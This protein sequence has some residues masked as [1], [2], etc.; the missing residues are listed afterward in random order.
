MIARIAWGTAL[1]LFSS[2]LPGQASIIPASAIVSPGFDQNPEVDGQTLVGLDIGGTGFSNLAGATAVTTTG[3]AQLFGATNEGT[4]ANDTEALTGLAFT[5]GRVN[6]GQSDFTL[7]ITVNSADPIRFFMGEIN[8]VGQDADAVRVQPLS[9]GNPISGWVIDLV[10]ANYG[11]QSGIWSP[12]AGL[13]N[14]GG[15]LTTFNLGDFS[16]GTPGTL[17]NVDGIRLLDNVG[18]VDCDPNVLGTYMIP[19]PGTFGLLALGFIGLFSQR[20]RRS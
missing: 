17:I 6:V 15:R 2:I 11:A 3:T 13:P 1:F 9:G 12:T 4:P 18:A 8:T 19:E 16:G 14:I 10:A 5:K 20:R 7:G